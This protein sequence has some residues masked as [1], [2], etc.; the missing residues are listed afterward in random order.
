MGLQAFIVPGNGH[1]KTFTF[2]SGAHRL[3]PLTG[4]PE[5]ADA[6]VALI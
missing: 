3:A 6:N 4:K 1:K 5:A 2:E